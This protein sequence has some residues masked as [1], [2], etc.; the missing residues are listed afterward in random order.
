MSDGEWASPAT[1][2]REGEARLVLVFSCGLALGL[3]A[4]ELL[5]LLLLLAAGSGARGL[6]SGFLARGAFQLLA[7]QLV[8]YFGGI[9]HVIPLSLESFSKF[10][11][12][13]SM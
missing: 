4:C 7:F 8:F 11:A 3:A 1:V 6:G 13:G 12:N 9:C 5:D 10:P 2:R